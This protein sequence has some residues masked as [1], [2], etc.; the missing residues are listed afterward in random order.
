MRL[1]KLKFNAAIFMAILLGMRYDWTT[2][3]I[4]LT[5]LGSKLVMWGCKAMGISAERIQHD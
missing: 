2:D 1:A 4:E 5:P 3:S